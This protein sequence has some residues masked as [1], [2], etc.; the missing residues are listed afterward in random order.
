VPLL[1][2]ANSNSFSLAFEFTVTYAS[3]KDVLQEYANYD[4]YCTQVMGILATFIMKSLLG[5]DIKNKRL[6]QNNFKM[7]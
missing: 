5:I 1:T 6:P 2:S 4:N 7:I 3:Q